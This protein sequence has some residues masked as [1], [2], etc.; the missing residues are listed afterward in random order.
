MSTLPRLPPAAALEAP[1]GAKSACV[2]LVAEPG[3]NQTRSKGSS[4]PPRPPS[5]QRPPTGPFSACRGDVV[6]SP[7]GPPDAGH[8]PP[9]ARRRGAPSG[10]PVERRDAGMVPAPRG[11]AR[12]ALG[13]GADPVAGGPSARDV[14]LPPPPV[15]RGAAAVA[16]GVGAAAGGRPGGTA[17]PRDPASRPGRRGGRGAGG[18]MVGLR[19]QGR[20]RRPAASGQGIAAVADHRAALRTATPWRW[21][22]IGWGGRSRQNPGPSPRPTRAFQLG[23]QVAAPW[24]GSGRA[25]GLTGHAPRWRPRT[26]W[27]STSTSFCVL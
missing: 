10:G 6:V 5:Y 23:H 25:G 14:R 4:T 2:L 21:R 24:A 19:G 11:A 8:G 17:R 1:P 3:R 13:G 9:L 15:R 27:C 7:D 16:G 12:P 26:P 20:A 22:L 18:G